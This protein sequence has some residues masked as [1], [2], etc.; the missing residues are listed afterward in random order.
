VDARRLRR[1]ALVA[2]VV[3]KTEFIEESLSENISGKK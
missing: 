2:N 1:R 3:V